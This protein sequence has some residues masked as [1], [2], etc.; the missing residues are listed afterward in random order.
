MS[1]LFSRA[2]AA[3]CSLEDCSDGELSAQ[4]KT[5]PFA[6][7]SST[8]GKMTDNWTSSRFGMTY[9]PLKDR[10]G[11]ERLTSFLVDF[12]VKPSAQLL[13]AAQLLPTCGQKCIASL[14]KLTPN[15]FSRK[16][17]PSKP[18]TRRHTTA[19]SADIILKQS[20]FP[21]K[22]WVQTI[23]DNDIGFL[24][25]PTT[26]ANYCAPS[27]YQHKGCENYIRVFGQRPPRDG[28]KDQST[29]GTESD[30]KNHK[31]Q[32]AGAKRWPYGEKDCPR[33]N[34]IDQEWLMGWPPGWTDT[35]PL[36]TDKFL[37]WLRQHFS[38]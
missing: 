34:P 38:S 36:A 13:T 29:R 31:K 28:Q 12:L 32:N 6:L 9:T 14:M 19:P 3:A 37:S 17:S 35:Q 25:T 8:S 7:I 18:L 23:A 27:M 11:E 20:L 5:I 1:W 26:A 30:A 16:M 4:L 33:P 22:T 10:R 24:H 2:L 15:S 21:R